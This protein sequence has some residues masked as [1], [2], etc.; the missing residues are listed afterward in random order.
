MAAKRTAG[1][2]L[3]DGFNLLLLTGFA[4]TAVYPFLNIAAL[5]FSAAD[6]V[7]RLGVRLIPDKWSLESYRA[8]L[9]NE[10]IWTSYG[11]TLFRTSLGTLLNVAFTVL[12]AYPLAKRQLPHRGLFT[13]LIVFTLFFSG[14]LIPTYLLIRELGLIDNRMVL[15]LPGLIA[16]FTMIIVRNY[17]MSLPG[18][19]EESAK[20][21]GANDFRILFSVIMPI[22]APIIATI[23]LWY[24]VGHWN[25]WFDALLYINDTD[26][27]VVQVILRNIVIEGLA[28]FQMYDMANAGSLLTPEGI[29]SATI[30]VA[31]VPIICVYPFIQKY[32]VKGIM[33]GSLKG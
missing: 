21:D 14:G 18:E 24:A 17:F 26:K 33:L 16:A 8:V 7:S 30:M 3:F 20:I 29:K 15:I 9:N 19:L 25:S 27:T 23:S 32:F 11:N 22:S 4:I 31:T 1:E 13:T 28:Q 5:S 10:F 2:R 12:C 6:S